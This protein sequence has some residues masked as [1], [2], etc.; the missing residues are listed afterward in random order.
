MKKIARFYVSSQ[1][2]LAL[3]VLIGLSSTANAKNKAPK[4]TPKYK[5]EK[6]DCLGFSDDI[7]TF[8]S[9]LQGAQ[10]IDIFGEGKTL[11]AAQKKA[12]NM[13]VE[14]YRNFA[15]VSNSEDSKSISQSGCHAFRST[16]DG[17]WESI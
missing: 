10:G 17:D 4:F 16:V 5:V 14:N 3:A 11:K 9:D 15:S 13:C 2:V 1:L 8:L 6:C 12:Q 7:P